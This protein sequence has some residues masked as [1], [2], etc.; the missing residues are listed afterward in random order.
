MYFDLNLTPLIPKEPLVY[1]HVLQFP[2][3]SDSVVFPKEVLGEHLG[4]GVQS[5]NVHNLVTGL[6][7]FDEAA[8][9]VCTTGAFI[10]DPV[11]IDLT[12][13]IS[14]VFPGS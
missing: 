13:L 7:L 3:D 10:T 9:F 5:L 2:G 8:N 14:Y 1:Q 11:L 6:Q 4:D 12:D